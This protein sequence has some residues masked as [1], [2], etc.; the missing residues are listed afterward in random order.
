MALTENNKK[1]WQS[2][3]RHRVNFLFFLHEVCL[4]KVVTNDAKALHSCEKSSNTNLLT[5]EQLNKTNDAVGA[6]LTAKERHS[7]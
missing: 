7:I 3:I 4:S 6:V 2:P 1:I 5:K